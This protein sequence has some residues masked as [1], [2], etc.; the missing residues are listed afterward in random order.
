MQLADAM[1]LLECV[2]C[3]RSV[4]NSQIGLQ[5]MTQHREH[6]EVLVRG[7][8]LFERSYCR[9]L[10]STCQIMQ[11]VILFRVSCLNAANIV[12]FCKY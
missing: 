5:V 3:V 1:T 2:A 12:D 6:A 10:V 9:F 4:M 11:T 8:G 7:R